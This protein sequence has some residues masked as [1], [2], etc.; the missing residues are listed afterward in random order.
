MCG[1]VRVQSSPH[2]PSPSP[3]DTRTRTK[4]TNTNM[5]P[6]SIRLHCVCL[7]LS[8]WLQFCTEMM[9]INSIS[10]QSNRGGRWMGRTI[11]LDGKWCFIT[12]LYK[13]ILMGRQPVCPFIYCG[14]LP[15][16]TDVSASASARATCVCWKREGDWTLQPNNECVKK[17]AVLTAHKD[18]D[19]M[20]FMWHFAATCCAFMVIVLELPTPVWVSEWVREIERVKLISN[21]GG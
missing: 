10:D 1:S 15:M 8:P 12:W 18:V 7:L 21:T 9:Q 20:A 6:P 3:S 2:L 17:G 4:K 11:E 13:V 5:V 19:L 14:F 16:L